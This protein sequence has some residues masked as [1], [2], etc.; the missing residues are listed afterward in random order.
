MTIPFWC[1][2]IVAFIPY[3]LALAGGY[4]KKRQFGSMDNADPRTQ[5]QQLTG[6]GART[7]ASQSNAWEALGFFTA[8]VVVAHLAGADPERSAVAAVVFLATRI[9]HPVFYLANLAALRSLAVT[10]GLGAGA[11]LFFLAAA[12]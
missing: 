6:A 10:V 7:W 9:L 3:F 8:A 2:M 5:A 12:A 11:Y 4:M 1:L